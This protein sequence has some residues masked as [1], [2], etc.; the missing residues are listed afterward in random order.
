MRKRSF[1]LILF[2]TVM[3]LSACS[4][5]FDQPDTAI[6]TWKPNSQPQGTTDATEGEQLPQAYRQILENLIGAFPWN[7]DP[8]DMVA[9]N[10]EL[11]YLYRFYASLSDIGFAVTDL[12]GNGQPELLLAGMDDDAV[13]DLY[14]LVD[15]QAVHLLDGGER[16][17]YYVRKDGVVENQWS[18]SAAMS[19]NDFFAIR[20][21]QL[22]FL[23]RVTYDAFHAE[24][25]GLVEDAWEATP[26]DSY[27]RSYTMHN[28]DYQH[29]TPQE[30][31]AIVKN[32]ESKYPALEIRYTL[33]SQ[34]GVQ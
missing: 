33:L 27:F 11:S 29:I 21:G 15:G 24:D 19:G 6:D 25:I 22:V 7:D 12:D 2:C 4:A 28:A 13:F 23:E 20:E 18:G 1:L 10:P 16:Y 30:A 31:E 5:A 8:E 26:E 3:I 32:Y 34:H 14:T 17:R 9:Q